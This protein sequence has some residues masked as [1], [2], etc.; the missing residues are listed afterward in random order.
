MTLKEKYKLEN[1]KG[2][3][4]VITL[5]KDKFKKKLLVI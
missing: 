1:N 4:K 3:K 5:Q 2:C